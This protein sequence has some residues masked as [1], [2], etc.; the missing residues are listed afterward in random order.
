MVR[1]IVR[2]TL[3]GLFLQL[4]GFSAFAQN[5]VKAE[6]PF[7][8]VAGTKELPAGAYEFSVTSNNVLMV[9]SAK[10]GDMVVPILTRLAPRP[11]API[12]YFDKS[13]DK[14]YLSE[15]YFSGVDGVHLQG[16]PGKHT[17]T[18]VAVK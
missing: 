9:R 1:N 13:E 2:V 10:S 14:S 16:A 17:H 3:A 12:I 4:L 8:F 5:I 15:V 18:K 6:I 11:D 7:A